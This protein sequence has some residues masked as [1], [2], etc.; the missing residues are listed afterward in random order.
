MLGHLTVVDK[1]LACLPAE[2]RGSLTPE[3]VITLKTAWAWL[4]GVNSIVRSANKATIHLPLPTLIEPV[5]VPEAVDDDVA[6][7]TTNLRGITI[8]Y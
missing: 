2:A 6:C 8:N 7:T 5:P 1:V 3:G 4:L